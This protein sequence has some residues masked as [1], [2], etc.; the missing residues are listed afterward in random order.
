MFHYVIVVPAIFRSFWFGALLNNLFE[1]FY[2]LIEIPCETMHIFKSWPQNLS[3]F[4]LSPC[5]LAGM[6]NFGE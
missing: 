2:D 3:L 6:I 1:K 5:D 4:P